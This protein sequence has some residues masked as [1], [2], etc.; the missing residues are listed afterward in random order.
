LEPAPTASWRGLGGT[1][2]GPFILDASTSFV[3][4]GL[5][6]LTVI[7]AIN[8][9]GAGEAGTGYLNAAVGVGGV[10][11]GVA[12]GSLLARPLR[13]PLLVGGLIGGVGLAGLGLSGS[14]PIAMLTIGIAVAG[15]L[16]LEIVTTTLV[17]RVVPDELRGRAVGVLQTTSSV[18]Y[19]AG[20]LALPVAADVAGV[21]PVL[22]ASALVT[23]IGVAGTLILTERQARPPAL[24]ADRAR[25]LA[26]PIFAGLPTSRLEAAARRLVEVPVE[27]G[28]AIV[29]EGEPAD[30]F[31]L[32][33]DGSLRVTQGPQNTHLRDL[34]PGD[35]FGEIG[36]LRRTPRTATVSALTPGRLLAL[37]ADA[38]ADL[39]GSGPGL[40]TKL[41][42]LYRGAASRA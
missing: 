10:V 41:L 29:R 26:H 32:V 23:V 18:I 6:V 14:L 27:A 40:S 1:L 9:L 42:D 19:S 11:A 24:D 39:V 17:Q 38:F 12:G 20:S 16:L 8:V 22:V 30:R 5:S 25:L 34:G 37:D 21:G 4:G 35:V 13:I 36:L 28:A 15:V 2:L 7:L 3:S 31:Y 33:A